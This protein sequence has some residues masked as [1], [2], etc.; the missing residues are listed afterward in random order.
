M[1]TEEDGTTINIKD[2]IKNINIYSTLIPASGISDWR[3]S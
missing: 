3:F 1:F 2:C